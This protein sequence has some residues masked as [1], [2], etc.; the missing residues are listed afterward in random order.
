MSTVDLKAKYGLN[1][2][3]PR[4]INAAIE[5]E[6]PGGRETLEALR[7]ISRERPD[8]ADRVYQ[9]IRAA[10]DAMADEIRRRYG[11]PPLE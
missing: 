8:P 4:A 10:A 5:A 9:A 1:K 3:T 11:L 7:V 2:S 6:L